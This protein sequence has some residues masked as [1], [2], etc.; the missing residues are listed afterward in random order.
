VSDCTERSKCNPKREMSPE[1]V[2][3]VYPRV[4]QS[5]E[6][7]PGRIEKSEAIKIGY[8]LFLYICR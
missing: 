1:E 2:I 6:Q 3:K 7:G 8:D 4:Y 5:K